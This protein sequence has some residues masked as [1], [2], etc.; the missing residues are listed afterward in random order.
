MAV[1]QPH[2]FLSFIEIDF[3]RFYS[4]MF[5]TKSKPLFDACF[6]A[7]VKAAYVSR[8]SSMQIAP[9]GHHPWIFESS[10]NRDGETSS[11]I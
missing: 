8:D 11:A 4:I 7:I 2:A 9:T 1:D 5:I 10:E 6:N 3:A